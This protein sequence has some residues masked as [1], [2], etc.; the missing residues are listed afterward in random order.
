MELEASVEKREVLGVVELVCGVLGTL[1]WGFGDL[2]C[3]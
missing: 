1:V 2:V 3:G